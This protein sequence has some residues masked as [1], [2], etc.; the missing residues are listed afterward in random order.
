MQAQWKRK[1][2]IA[3]VQRQGRIVLAADESALSTRE[4]DTRPVP[5]TRL[6]VGLGL[7]STLV[8][9][10][11]PQEH[12]WVLRIG[13]PVPPLAR[14]VGIWLHLGIISTFWEAWRDAVL[15][16]LY[17]TT[18]NCCLENALQQLYFAQFGIQTRDSS[19]TLRRKISSASSNPKQ[20]L[21]TP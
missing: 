2:C 4:P 21:K 14:S 7:E 6:A 9:R 8:L 19:M 18:G 13:F 10:P 17:K 1:A 12:G 3:K 20:S 16:G 15:F 11:T 5:P